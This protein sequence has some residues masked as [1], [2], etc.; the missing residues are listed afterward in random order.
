[1]RLDHLLSKDKSWTYEPDK[2]VCLLH[3]LCLF[4]FEGAIL[5]KLFY[6]KLFLFVL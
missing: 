1:V 6:S 4:S 3:V 2:T 5:S